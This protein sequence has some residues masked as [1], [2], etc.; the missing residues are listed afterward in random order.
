[1][2]SI[3]IIIVCIIAFPFLMWFCFSIGELVRIYIFKGNESKRHTIWSYIF[4]T[5]IGLLVCYI[6]IFIHKLR[7]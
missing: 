6:L 1:M 3:G 2:K 4:Y 7:N 5:I